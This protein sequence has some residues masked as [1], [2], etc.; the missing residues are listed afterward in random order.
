MLSSGSHN[1]ALARMYQML[2]ERKQWCL[3]ADGLGDV[4]KAIGEQ[5]KMGALTIAE[6]HIASETLT[7]A[8]THIGSGLPVGVSSRR[9][10]L[11]TVEGD[12]HELGLRLAELC[13]RARQWEPLWLGRDTPTDVLI[14]NIGSENLDLVALSASVYGVISEELAKHAMRVAEVC[15]SQGILLVLGG[16]GTW[17]EVEGAVRVRSFSEFDTLLERVS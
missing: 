11:A 9:A 6:E 2:H 8:L 7:R 14:D 10:V 17:P 5:W 13:L 3:V 4:L 12:T 15:R 16:M 1:A